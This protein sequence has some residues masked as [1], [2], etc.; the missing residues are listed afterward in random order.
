M[1]PFKPDSLPLKNLNWSLFIELIGSANA[2]LARYDGVIRG[3]PN[4]FVLLSPLRTNEAVLSSKIEGTQATLQD[5]LFYEA[6]PQPEDPR[7]ADIQEIIN[8]RKALVYA[9]DYLKKRPINLNMIKELH[10]LLMDSVRGAD[11]RPGEFRTTQNWIGPHG[12]PIEA[13]YFVPPEP[14]QIQ[15]NLSNLEKYIHFQER[16]RLVQLAVIHAQFEIIHPFADGNGRLGR[17]LIP[18]FLFSN[19]LLIEPCFY[20]SEYMEINRDTYNLALRDISNSGNWDG[21]INFFLKAVVS[22]AK[23]NSEKAI[24]ILKLYDDVKRKV[25]ALASS[26][27][28]PALDSLFQFPIFSSPDF[29]QYSGIPRASAAR[30]LGNMADKGLLE[31]I[32]E[33]KG[34]RPTIYRFSELISIISGK[35]KGEQK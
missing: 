21:W 24:A 2:E 12:A 28:L 16:D 31:I 10:S 14:L 8:Y 23:S 33:G 18:L 35:N 6:M 34:K 29:V 27:S 1:K 3:I 5:V 9:V 25:H 4:P 26:Y 7:L 11:K 22:Q 13:A 20:M 15:D 17:M 19:N 30:L 32:Q